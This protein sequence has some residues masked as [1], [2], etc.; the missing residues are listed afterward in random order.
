MKKFIYTLFVLIIA[1]T[2][3]WGATNDTGNQ[4]GF[5]AKVA[6]QITLSGGLDGGQRD[7][8]ILWQGDTESFYAGIDDSADSWI[9]GLGSTMATTPLITIADAGTAAPTIKLTGNITNTEITTAANVLTVAECGKTIFLDDA[10]GV[11]YATTL[12]VATTAGCDFTFKVHTAVGTTDYTVGTNGGDNI[13]NG[14]V[15]EDGTAVPCVTE[16]DLEFDNAADAKGDWVSV[17]ADG[18][19]WYVTGITE[20]ASSFTCSN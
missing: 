2:L 15:I 9:L 17:I 1:V 7:A 14:V 19:S 12:P 4:E 20:A 3:A 11:G 6:P 5:R 16:D 13:I 8:F 18:T 10:S